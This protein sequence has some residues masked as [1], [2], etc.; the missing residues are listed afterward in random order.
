MKYIPLTEAVKRLGKSNT[1]YMYNAR[2]TKDMKKHKVGGVMCITEA[3]FLDLLE[4]VDIEREF[5]MEVTIFA[6]WIGRIKKIRKLID[7]VILTENYEFVKDDGYLRKDLAINVLNKYDYLVKP[8]LKEYEGSGI[9][10]KCLEAFAKY[11]LC[12]R[13]NPNLLKEKI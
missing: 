2:F 3:D 4:S 6:E 9:K 11:V 8:F 5:K 12:K 7:K 10:M 1:S 13:P